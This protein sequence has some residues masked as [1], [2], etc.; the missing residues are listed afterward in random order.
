MNRYK[1][2]RLMEM[3]EKEIQIVIYNDSHLT[4]RYQ[5]SV[6]ILKLMKLTVFLGTTLFLCFLIWFG[7][8]NYQRYKFLNTAYRYETQQIVTLKNFKCQIE[9]V[10]NDIFKITTK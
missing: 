7:I 4:D 1:K 9:N 5:I 8:E 2:R 3:K 6:R 10:E